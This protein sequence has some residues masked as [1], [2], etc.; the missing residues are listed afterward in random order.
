MGTFLARICSNHPFE[1]T[2]RRPLEKRLQDCGIRHM[3]YLVNLTISKEVII[4]SLVIAIMSP[5]TAIP[6][7]V[8]KIQ[9]L[10]HSM[11]S[12]VV[13]IPSVEM[14]TQSTATKTWW[15]EIKT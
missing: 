5:V 12:T 11:L 2:F 8:T 6:P 1:P 14:L 10:A 9:L 4:P 7:L 13:P 3:K 15:Q